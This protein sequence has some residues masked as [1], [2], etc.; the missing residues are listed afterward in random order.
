LF[1]YKQ[2]FQTSRKQS[3]YE[4][5]L[6]VWYY[7]PDDLYAFASGVLFK[8]VGIVKFI[9][10]RWKKCDATKLNKYSYGLYKKILLP[11]LS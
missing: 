8:N 10:C 2:F 4:T 5:K 1:S 9:F 7:F 6:H 11:L 3:V